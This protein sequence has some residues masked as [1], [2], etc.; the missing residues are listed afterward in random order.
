MTIKQ[1]NGPSVFTRAI[2]S[3]KYTYRKAWQEKNPS[4]KSEQAKR[5]KENN[6]TFT[7]KEEGKE[8]RK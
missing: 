7:S 1:S 2:Q 4:L 3:S 5:E 6:R 8:F